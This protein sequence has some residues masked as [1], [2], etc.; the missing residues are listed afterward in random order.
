MYNQIIF[1][2]KQRK[3]PFNFLPSLLVVFNLKS[4]TNFFLRLFYF[5]FISIIVFLHFLVWTFFIFEKIRRSFYLWCIE[6]VKWMEKVINEIK[7]CIRMS[8]LSIFMSKKNSVFLTPKDLPTLKMT[9]LRL[10]IVMYHYEIRSK[11]K[12]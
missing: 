1:K 7:G 3:S 5:F 10:K 12:L 9:Y 8:W 6:L 11:L 4:L 2:R